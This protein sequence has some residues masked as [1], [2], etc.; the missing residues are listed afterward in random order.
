MFK[1][2]FSHDPIEFDDMCETFETKQGELYLDFNEDLPDVSKEEKELDKLETLFK[3]GK[4]SDTDFEKRCQELNEIIA[5][6]HNYTYVGRVGLFTPVK[7]GSGG[8]VLYRVDKRKTLCGFWD[9]RLS[10]ER[11]RNC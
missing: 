9:N 2:L 5:T 11:I 7:E 4:L 3:K 1:S 10:L 6:G 8:G